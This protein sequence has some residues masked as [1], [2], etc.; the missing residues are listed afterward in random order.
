M[1]CPVCGSNETV[2]ES[3]KSYTGQKEPGKRASENLTFAF[4][5]VFVRCKKCN[6]SLKTFKRGKKNG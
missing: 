1:T 2:E 3:F 6:K 5:R 4:Y